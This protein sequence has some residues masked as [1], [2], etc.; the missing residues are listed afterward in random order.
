MDSR[1]VNVVAGIHDTAINDCDG[2]GEQRTAPASAQLAAAAASLNSPYWP[3]GVR[4][5]RVTLPWDVADPGAI[6]WST[7]GATHTSD[8]AVD[9]A[10]LATTK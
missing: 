9:K 6:D 4:T 3:A 10:A 7:G 5:V 1:G 8:A 2:N